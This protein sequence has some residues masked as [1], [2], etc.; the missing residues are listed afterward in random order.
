MLFCRQRTRFEAATTGSLWLRQSDL[1]RFDR[2]TGA[3][4]ELTWCHR[5]RI[6]GRGTKT[7]VPSA[8][9]GPLRRLLPFAPCDATLP[10][11]PARSARSRRRVAQRVR[12]RRRGSGQRPE[13][14]SSS[15]SIRTCRGAGTIGSPVE[16]SHAAVCPSRARSRGDSSGC[17]IRYS[18]VGAPVPAF[19]PAA[20]AAD[21]TRR[22]TSSPALTPAP[23]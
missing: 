8:H 3:E 5:D 20:R 16:T 15:R 1:Q 7:P 19:V 4:C 11:W 10:I 17:R 21:W 18:C 2:R 6:Q 14:S 9:R 13:R 23:P 12:G 22:N